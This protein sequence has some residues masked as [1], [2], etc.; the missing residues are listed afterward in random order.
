LSSCHDKY[1]NPT[2]IPEPTIPDDVL[3]TLK[4]FAMPGL[5]DQVGVTQGDESF[6]LNVPGGDY[7]LNYTTNTGNVD[8]VFRATEKALLLITLEPGEHVQEAS[9]QPGTITVAA[10]SFQV[11]ALTQG[12]VILFSFPGNGPAWQTIFL[13]SPD[14][15]VINMICG[16]APCPGVIDLNNPD[17][18]P[19]PQ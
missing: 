9:L 11:M 2:T 1:E 8:V 7:H 3:N 10:K 19:F 14:A 16:G 17:S 12:P 5:I 15:G 4:Y 18:F 6:Q 13:I